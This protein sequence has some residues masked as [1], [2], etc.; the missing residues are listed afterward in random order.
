MDSWMYVCPGCGLATNDRN[1]LKHHLS[2][3]SLCTH[4]NPQKVSES[5]RENVNKVCCEILEETGNFDRYVGMQILTQVML[6]DKTIAFKD[7]K[8]GEMSSDLSKML[9][10]SKFKVLVS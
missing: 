2:D 3:F 8:T 9:D 7:M 10:N 6:K 4:S 5:Q 1:V